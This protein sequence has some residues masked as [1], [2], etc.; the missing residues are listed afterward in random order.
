MKT[1]KLLSIFLF[2]FSIVVLAIL[3]KLMHW[4]GAN[5]ML[6]V[7]MS[8]LSIISIL[9]GFKIGNSKSGEDFWNN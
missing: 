4:P 8:T 6:I 1:K 9:L 2:A 7:G 5:I 3:Y